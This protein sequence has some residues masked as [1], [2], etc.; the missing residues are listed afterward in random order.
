M[1]WVRVLQGSKL[2]P[3]NDVERF[4]SQL[5]FDSQEKLKD[6]PLELGNTHHLSIKMVRVLLWSSVQK[7]PLAMPAER[8][9]S[10]LQFENSRKRGNFRD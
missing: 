7:G 4:L 10:M 8:I 3:L 1:H 9:L 6:F 2:E 5:P